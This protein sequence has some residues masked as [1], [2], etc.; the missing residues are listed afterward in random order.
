MKKTFFILSLIPI[1]LT[2]LIFPYIQDDLILFARVLLYGLIG[3]SFAVAIAFLFLLR[4]K[5]LTI[6]AQRKKAQL[7]SSLVISNGE[8]WVQEHI[9]KT[10][11]QGK[12]EVTIEYARLGGI[13]HRVNSHDHNPTPSEI[14]YAHTMLSTGQS[15]QLLPGE[16]SPGTIVESKPKLDLL[17]IFTQPTQ[18]YAIIG[19]QQVGKTFQ[20]IRVANYWLQSGIEPIVI[21]PKW[22][23]GEWEGCT[24]FGGEYDFEK[25]AQG[26]QIIK[27]LAMDRHADTSKSHKQHSIQPVFF[28]DWTAIRATIKEES[29]NF[30]IDATTLYASVNIILYFIIHLDTGA[31]WGV[32]KVGASLKNNF[33]KLI[34]QPGYNSLGEI[35][36]TKNIGWLIMPGQTIKDKQKVDLFSG[37][38]STL[39][40]PDLVIQP[41]E[42]LAQVERET[43]DAK[44]VRLV[45]EGKSRNEAAQQAWGRR[46]AGDLVER[47]KVLLGEKAST[48]T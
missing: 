23:K 42:N 35:D 46:Y 11:E 29:E 21:G 30:I 26:M 14:L 10:N 9:F 2:I 13:R 33:I 40:L 22:D 7:E 39:A 6:Q 48:T 37:N 4:E 47:G 16:Y 8:T 5:F 27:K 17:R 19:G 25:V 32:D 28:D 24:K 20:A 3:L 34:V 18:S 43:N 36:R 38:G 12:R 1:T 41:S 15:K 31:A 44:F 45:G